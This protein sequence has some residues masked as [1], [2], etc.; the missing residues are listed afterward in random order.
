MCSTHH[1][2]RPVYVPEVFVTAQSSLQI[3]N[4]GFPCRSLQGTRKLPFCGEEY[5]LGG[6]NLQRSFTYSARRHAGPSCKWSGVW[7]SR[8]CSKWLLHKVNFL[9]RPSLCSSFSLASSNL[10][11]PR[12]AGSPLHLWVI[13]EGISL[14]LGTF[15]SRR[16]PST[17]VLEFL[18]FRG[19]S[20][21]SLSFWL[22]VIAGEEELSLMD[23]KHVGH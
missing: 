23:S 21:G 22:T 4:F 12:R 5:P 14:G 9:F 19:Q 3:S 16:P 10:G 6:R 2:W 20:R 15:I 11:S 8:H 7:P 18:A 17:C 13:S 1:V